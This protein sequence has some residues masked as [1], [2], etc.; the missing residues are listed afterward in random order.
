MTLGQVYS[1]TVIII[2][3]DVIHII[4]TEVTIH[5]QTAE[6]SLSSGLLLEKQNLKVISLI[7]ASSDGWLDLIREIPTFTLES[8]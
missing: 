1:K 6:H 4:F 7:K 2:R 5:C 8:W 3:S